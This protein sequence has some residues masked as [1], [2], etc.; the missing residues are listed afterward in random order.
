M[1]YTRLPGQT[2]IKNG[3]SLNT[4]ILFWFLAG[5]PARLVI[6]IS[7]TKTVFNKPVSDVICSH[8]CVPGLQRY[9]PW[10]LELQK[11]TTED[12]NSL[13]QIWFHSN[14]ISIHNYASSILLLLYQRHNVNSFR[15]QYQYSAVHNPPIHCTICLSESFCWPYKLHKMP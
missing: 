10:Q 5:E 15:H 14:S 2:V 1:Y 6:K 11:K 13:M 3:R 7:L 4:D 8:T 9:L 12:Q